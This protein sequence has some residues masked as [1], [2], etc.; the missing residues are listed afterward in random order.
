MFH[1]INSKSTLSKEEERSIQNLFVIVP[2][3]KKIEKRVLSIG[4]D[5]T[6]GNGKKG[7]TKKQTKKKKKE[8]KKELDNQETYMQT[9]EYIE[10][11]AREKLGMVKDGEIL[12][13]AR[14]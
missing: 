3:K 13:K 1:D 2:T 9:D 7:K 5:I 10:E 8:K 6:K 14:E 12:F 11:V 4:E